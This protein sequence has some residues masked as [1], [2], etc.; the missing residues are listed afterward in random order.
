[1]KLAA[2]DI[3]SNSIKLV[4][5]EAS[6]SESFT[7]LASDRQVVRLGHETL[8]K[9][10]IGDDAIERATNCLKQ[11][12]KIAEDCGAERIVASA[13]ASVR[14]ANNSSDFIRA[15]EEQ[16]GLR[17]EVLSGIEEAR[18][19]GLAAAH[20]C[21]DKG[22]TSLNID[23]GG[24]STEISIFQNREPLK[25]VSVKLGAV[26]LTD[27][28]LRSDPP[29]ASEL[30][31]LRSE[32][33]VALEASASEL[34]E[35]GWDYTTATSGTALTIGAALNH[36]APLTESTVTLAQLKQLN[37]T[38]ASLTISERHT[39]AGLSP[40]RAD[41]IVAGGFVLEGVMTALGI[42]SLRTCDWSLREGVIIDRL[43]QWEPG[44]L[45]P[46]FKGKKTS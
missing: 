14:E 4:V 5:V 37:E 8:V 44:V 13:T 16:T 36:L 40:Q 27:R 22:V 3:G 21:T 24:G 25:L 10:H 34:R 11:F 7:V 41:I 15:V 9:G 20:G 17:V 2:I 28:F 31:D 18:L 46:G 19:I 6:T 45:T 29:A 1:M 23:I 33:R 39:I 30:D 26:G 32:V 38:L 12:R 43:R 42:E 35:H